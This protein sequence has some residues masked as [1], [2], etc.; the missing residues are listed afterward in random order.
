M[1][2]VVS[3]KCVNEKVLCHPEDEGKAF[4]ARREKREQEKEKK[5]EKEGERGDLTTRTDQADI[6]LMCESR[7]ETKKKRGNSERKRKE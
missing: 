5:R 6:R 3:R 1:I 7:N 4:S 2:D